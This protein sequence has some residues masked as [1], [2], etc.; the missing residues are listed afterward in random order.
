M[1]DTDLTLKDRMKALQAERDYR[2]DKDS[3][4]LCH[5][6]GRAF[7]KMIKKKFRLPFDDDFMRMM[8]DTAAYVCEN[9]QGA[10]LAY[11][12]SDEITVVI[13]NFKY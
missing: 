10:K 4:I 13:T 8:D 3:Y 6:D 2:L 11:V 1:F 5:I 7:S 9:V 12:Q